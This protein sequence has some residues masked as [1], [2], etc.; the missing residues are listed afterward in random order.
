MSETNTTDTGV[1]QYPAG[2]YRLL[3]KSHIALVPGGEVDVRDA[4][5]EITY[6]GKPGPHM[7]PLDDAAKKGV[8]MAGPMLSF[9]Q[10]HRGGRNVGRRVPAENKRM[11]GMLAELAKLGVLKAQDGATV[12]PPSV[13]MRSA[14][15]GRQQFGLQELPIAPPPPPPPSVDPPPP[16]PPPPDTGKKK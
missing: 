15:V 11:A 13:P 12:P 8:E 1:V 4:G 14:E 10:F 3:A 9:A 7:L 6:A 5:T 2:R 16:P